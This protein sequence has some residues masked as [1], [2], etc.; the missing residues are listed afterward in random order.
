MFTKF[1]SAY[2]SFKKQAKELDLYDAIMPL[3]FVSKILGLAPFSLRGKRGKR[4][5]VANVGAF[6]FIRIAC[7]ISAMAYVGYTVEKTHLP[8]DIGGVAIRVELYL[9]ATL[10][11]VVLF[12]A[13]AN[14]NLVILAVTSI[15]E[16]DRKMR[17]LA[18]NITYK[19]ARKISTCQSILIL[20][21]FTTKGII[22]RF[23][24]SSVFI[25]KNK[26]KK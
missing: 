15:V 14:Q 26:Q 13:I 4:K 5:F 11:M 19:N 6:V 20:S 25:G 8:F 22:Q 7:I 1:K 23:S 24:T 21:L 18:I 12:L 10:S 16:V 2:S 17:M 9:G 3:Y